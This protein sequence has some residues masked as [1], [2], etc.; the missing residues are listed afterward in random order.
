MANI[1]LDELI[2][3]IEQI[4]SEGAIVLLKWDGERVSKHCTVVVTRQSTDWVW[5]KDTNNITDALLE[6]IADYRKH[7]AL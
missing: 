5:R 6:A 1:S 3:E 2:P 7:H 4:R